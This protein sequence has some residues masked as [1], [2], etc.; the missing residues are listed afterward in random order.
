M[1]HSSDLKPRIFPI[2]GA[3][4]PAEIDRAQGIDPNVTMNRT[5]IT[6]VGRDGAVGY[7]KRSPTVGYRLTQ[8]EYGSIEFFQKLVMTDSLGNVGQDGIDLNDF[9]TPYFDIVSYITDD[10]DTFI[11]TIHYPTLRTSGFSVSIADPQATIE[12]SF[13]FIGEKAFTW[14]NDNKYLVVNEKVLGSAGDNTVV[15]G[16][17]GDF[18]QIPVKDPDT[19][20]LSDTYILRV[21]HVDDSAGTSSVLVRGTDWSYS[22]GAKTLTIS[23]SVD[24]SDT[25]R[26]WYSSSDAP[27]VQFTPNDSDPSALAGESADIFMMVGDPSGSEDRL[28]RLQSI[29]LDV[30]LDRED[31]REIGNN[32][33]TQRGVK[34]KT[35]TITLGRLLEDFTIEEILRDKLGA[36]Y[37]KIDVEKFVDNI[38]IVVKIYEDD[39]KTTLKYGFMA[40]NLSPSELRGGIATEEYTSRENALIGESL[41]ISKDNSKIGNIT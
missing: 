18:T 30:A 32:D 28:I 5:K 4:S 41:I 15:F 6:E 27:T 29:T 9:K 13:D 8:L 16:S 26:I 11:G 7:L 31:H 40:Q 12:R 22:D 1:N 35:V 10:D 34:S 3:G 17:A 23:S 14:Q 2:L 36:S 20:G 39:T 37:G 38:T 19:N 33:V 21:V 24:A 25:I